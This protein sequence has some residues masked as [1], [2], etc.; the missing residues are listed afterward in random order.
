MDYSKLQSMATKR[1][2]NASRAGKVIIAQQ[3]WNLTFTAQWDYLCTNETT[4]DILRF[5]TK[6]INQAKKWLREYMAN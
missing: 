6:S 4:G 3:Q 5:N 2:N 1:A